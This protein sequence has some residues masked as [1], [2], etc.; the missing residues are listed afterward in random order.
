MMMDIQ[1]RSIINNLFEV[2]LTCDSFRDKAIAPSQE[3]AIEKAIQRLLGQFS[4][5]LTLVDYF[6]LVPD[7]HLCIFK[8]KIAILGGLAD[9]YFLSETPGLDNSLGW[10]PNGV[11][12][13]GKVSITHK[14]LERIKQFIDTA[15]Y[16][17]ALHN[18]EHFANYILHGLPLSSQQMTWHK[19]LGA[20]ILGRLQ[21]QQSIAE[22]IL[23]DINRQ[24]KHQLQVERAKRARQ[25]IY[26]FC[27][28]RQIP[29][30]LEVI[31]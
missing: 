3:L 19:G 15:R 25:K 21:P 26:R 31:P 27:Q 24:L 8:E 18:C 5:V 7:N 23:A 14:Q 13:R 11:E 2:T 22:N 16:H 10:G 20:T 28:E 30:Q 1:V 4:Q 6:E 9:H 17:L 12:L 29:L